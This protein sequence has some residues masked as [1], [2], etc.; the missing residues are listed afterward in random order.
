[1][2]VLSLPPGKTTALFLP[3][4]ID[5]AFS[6]AGGGTVS[7]YLQA[8]RIAVLVDAYWGDPALETVGGALPFSIVKQVMEMW[9]T[10]RHKM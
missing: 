8:V 7:V 9:L 3:G 1:M 2:E 4:T 6:T 10:E 5:I